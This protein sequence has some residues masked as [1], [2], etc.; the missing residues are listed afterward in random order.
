M[1]GDASEPSCRLGDTSSWRTERFRDD[2]DYERAAVAVSGVPWVALKPRGGNVVLARLRIDATQGIVWD[3][4]IDLADAP[5]YPVA[6]DVDDRRFVMLTTTQINWNGDVELWRIDRT[7]GTVLRV[8][9]GNPPSDPAFTIYS[10]IGLAGDDVVLGYGRAAANEGAVE[11]RDDGL[12]V[13]QTLPVSDYSF[14]AVHASAAAVDLYVG[15]TQRLHVEGGVIGAQP[16]D[17]SWQVFGGLDDL[18]VEVGQDIR[19]TR[20]G[21]A[22]VWPAAWPHTQI[23]PPAVVRTD[24]QG[25]VAFSLETELTAVIGV[26]PPADPLEWLR[27]E[28]AP[29]APG[30]GLGLLPVIEPGRVGVFYLG[31]E[32]PHPEQPLRYYGLACP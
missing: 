24:A 32:I 5:V 9:V 26:G 14:T 20:G 8:P 27:I 4:R 31:L 12:A 13:L 22:D 19:L 16:V 21:G 18:R 29:A 15:T 28:A 30:I 7:S 6:L 2:G 1:A 11:L 3:E 23:S 25:H 17:P 10:A